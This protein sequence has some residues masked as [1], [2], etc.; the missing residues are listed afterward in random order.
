ML[1]NWTDGRVSCQH[2]AL[3]SLLILIMLH[4]SVIHGSLSCSCDNLHSSL[5]S[6][7]VF[8]QHDKKL[9]NTRKHAVKFEGEPNR[10]PPYVQLKFCQ[11]YLYSCLE[12]YYNRLWVE[13]FPHVR[14]WELFSMSYTSTCSS[15]IIISHLHL[16]LC[17]RFDR[18]GLSSFVQ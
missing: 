7:T 4:V 5:R 11:W 2:S 18:N 3:A 9:A 10:P 16:T 8:V 12:I 17:C 14:R 13:C 1:G 6:L 15:V